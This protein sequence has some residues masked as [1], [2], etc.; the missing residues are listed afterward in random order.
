MPTARWL[1]LSLLVLAAPAAAEPERA[2]TPGDV[3]FAACR[4]TDPLPPE[5]RLEAL[6]HVRTGAEIALAA[7]PDDP[8]AHLA[9][10]CALGRR[11]QLLGLGIPALGEVRR[12]RRLIDHVLTLAPDWA[13]AIAA[14]GGFLCALPRL[15]G[16][17]RPQGVRLLRRAMLL[18]P[19]NADARRLLI[20]YGG[21]DA[22]PPA[23]AGSSLGR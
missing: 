21:E 15:L 4:A 13:E 16:G 6:E 10:F 18:D 11:R 8:A 12:M 7:A 5:A 3:A 2:P 14:K 9:V 19:T 1:L 17:D 20:E 22:L 23:L